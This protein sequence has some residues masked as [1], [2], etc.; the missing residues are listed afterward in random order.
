M[1]RYPL[2]ISP[3][4]L[5][6]LED[7]KPWVQRGVLAWPLYGRFLNEGPLLAGALMDDYV[8]C[9]ANTICCAGMLSWWPG[10]NPT[11]P[12]Y[13]SSLRPFVELAEQKRVRI[14]FVVFCDTRSLMPDRASQIAHWERVLTTLGDKTNVTFVAVNQPGHP[15]QS[16]DPMDF[17]PLPRFPGLLCARDNPMESANPTVPPLDFSCYCSSRNYPQGFV[18][19]GSSM[20][21]VVNGWEDHGNVWVGSH[22]VSVLFEP[23]HCRV[24]DWTGNPGVWRQLA[25]SLTFQGTGGGNMYSDALSQAQPLVGIER[26]CAVEFL[27]NLPT[28]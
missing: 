11:N 20:W 4:R 24:T 8:A 5:T 17:N 13:W 2:T 28:P 15:T 6:F 16:C 22:Q 12:A 7:G 9:G 23:L 26:A 18:E 1:S 25:R 27:G 10:L 21:Y 14:C 3:D 19:V